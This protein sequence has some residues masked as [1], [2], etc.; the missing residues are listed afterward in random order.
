[1]GRGQD[2]EAASAQRARVLDELRAYE[3]IS[4]EITKRFAGTLGLHPTDAAALVEIL[5]AEERGA[6]LSPAR[7]SE[8]IGLTSG[9]TSSLLNRLE[10]GGHIVRSR[11]HS[12]RRVVTL[13]S[14]SRVQEEASAFFDPL[15]VRLS[16]L[17]NSYPDELM[18][19]FESFLTELRLTTE[20]HIQGLSS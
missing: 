16:E 17:M 2:H 1:M 13:R 18:K 4:T 11:I 3:A 12:D 9:A 15:A 10:E 20:A 8:R 19:Q 6:P 5:D 7:L 14:T